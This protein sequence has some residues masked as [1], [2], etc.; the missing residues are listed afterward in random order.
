MNNKSVDLIGAAIGWG[1]RDHETA[2]GPKTLR[3]LGIISALEKDYP[4][5]TWEQLETRLLF[6][7][8]ENLNYAQ[9]EDEIALFSAQLSQT[10]FDSL[11]KNHFPLIVGG[12]HTLAI[13]TWSGVVKSLQAQCQFGLI[14]I[15]AHM[16]AHTLE[17][18]E[19][20]AINGMPLAVLLGY[21]DDKL[22]NIG[23]KGAK[24][25]PAHLVLIGVRSFEQA[26]ALRLKQLDVQVYDMDA[27]KE[28]GFATVLGKAL[29]HVN[30]E[31]KGFGI[32]I[33]LDAFDPR[34]AP[35]V[36]NP[37]P[38]GLFPEMVLG[39]LGNAF[40]LPQCKALEIA[41][42]NPSRDIENKTA[43]LCKALI[44]NCLKK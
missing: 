21:G 44:V 38:N 13:G 14:W 26:E 5:L 16:D 35:G 1:S 27:V 37:E 24:I 8:N 31:T 4:R 43:S 7:G 33:D 6:S 39:P 25:N 12:D 15:D 22:I 11:Q 28:L 3:A 41:E 34:I 36:G 20:Y 10:V 2:W 32:S 19:S 9:R 29:T 18:T 30:Q 17:T 40:H 23:L 42:Y